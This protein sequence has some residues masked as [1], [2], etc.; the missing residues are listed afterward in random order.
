MSTSF[1]TLATR[2]KR[3]TLFVLSTWNGSTAAVSAT[4]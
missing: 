2:G 1:R 3:A 4:V